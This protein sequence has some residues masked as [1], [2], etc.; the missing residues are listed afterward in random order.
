MATKPKSEHVHT[1]NG[2]GFR[3]AHCGAKQDMAMPCD[4][5][6][7]IAAGK[8]FTKSHARCK[9]PGKTTCAFCLQFGHEY[10]TCPAIANVEQWLRCHDTGLSSE[11]LAKAYLSKRPLAEPYPW[12]PDD[13][14]RCYRLMKRY[15]EILEWFWIAHFNCRVWLAYKQ[16][17]SEM[18]RLY[19]EEL[20]SGK[21]PKLWALMQRL[22][23][24]AQS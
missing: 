17:W 24:Q 12:D 9:A 5:N 8:A 4:I 16:N 13:F 3:C 14:G 7:W 20:P 23:K 19:E 15:P 6:V 10:Q 21:A 22:E 1:L 18:T 11:Q 2:G